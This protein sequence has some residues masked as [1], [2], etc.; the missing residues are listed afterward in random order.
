[1]TSA[2]TNGRDLLQLVEAAV[3]GVDNADAQGL[4]QRLC[5]AESI[6]L[7]VLSHPVRLIIINHAQSR[8]RLIAI[9]KAL[10]GIRDAP[11]RASSPHHAQRSSGAR[12]TASSTAPSCWMLS[13][14]SAR[15]VGRL[16]LAKLHA[17][18]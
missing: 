8:S 13:Q 18:P 14:T 17:I 5:Q 15:Y 16:R 9:A 12:L 2:T 10:I 11:H 1:M 7:N 4:Y 6:L 3:Y